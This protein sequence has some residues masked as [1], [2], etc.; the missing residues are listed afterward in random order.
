MDNVQDVNEVIVSCALT[1]KTWK[2][3]GSPVKKKKARKLRIFS[4]SSI[5]ECTD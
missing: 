5:A 3:F 2:R 1:V 4:Q